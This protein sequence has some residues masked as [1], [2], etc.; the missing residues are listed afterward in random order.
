MDTATT[1]RFQIVS[2]IKA[3]LKP[4]LD[5]T[6]PRV[7]CHCQEPAESPV[8]LCPA[9]LADIESVDPV[10]LLYEMEGALDSSLIS[11]IFA[12]WMFDKSG[13]LSSVHRLLKYGNRPRLGYEMGILI[14]EALSINDK[15]NDKIETKDLVV[16]VPLHRIRF[17]ERGYN[18][19][20]QLAAG[21]CHASG[22][23]LT[24]KLVSRAISTQTQTGLNRQE[25]ID[26][27]SSAFVLNT[28]IDLSGHRCIIV[29]DILTTGATVAS[30]AQTLADAGAEKI[31]VV[32]LGFTRPY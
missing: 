5:F 27:V 20:E 3:I 26:N 11:S 7:C 28:D 4:V 16:P 24:P 22:A 14:A 15:V 19:S 23:T 31:S 1:S 13:P 6:F 18:Q 10:E 8:Q 29:D 17:L 25:R 9:C 12:L 21:I 2:T 32:A 30:L